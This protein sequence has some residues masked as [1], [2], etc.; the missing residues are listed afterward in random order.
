MDY[1]DGLKEH[2]KKISIS[3][4]SRGETQALVEEKEMVQAQIK[5]LDGVA[6]KRQLVVDEMKKAERDGR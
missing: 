6:V 3:I 2:L 1:I 4:N 5:R